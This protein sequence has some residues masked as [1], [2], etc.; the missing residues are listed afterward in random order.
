MKRSNVIKTMVLGGGLL[1]LITG[2]F[3]SFGAAGEVINI[4]TVAGKRADIGDGGLATAAQLNL[5]AAVAFGSAGA[6]YITEG[7]GHRVRK[8]DAAGI[9]TTFAGIGG[10]G[11]S[12][13]AGQAAAAQFNAPRGALVDSF[14]NLYIVET[15]GHRVRKI[16]VASGIVTTVVGTGVAG[17]A[18]DGGPATAAQLNAPGFAALDSS[19]NLYVSEVNANR[20]RKVVPGASGSIAGA[21]DEIISTVAGSGVAGSAG[22]GGLATAAQ[23]RNP[24]G[25]SVDASGNLYIADVNNQRVRKVDLEGIIT[26]FAGTGVAGFNGD[27]IQA[28]SAQLNG[29]RTISV[30]ASGSLYIADFNNN[31]VRKVNASGMITTIVGTGTRG[32]SGDDGLATAAQLNGPNGINIDPLGNLYISE[33]LG[34]HIRKVDTTGTITTFA[35]GGLPQL[36]DGG[37]ATAAQFDPTSGVAFDAS[38]NLYIADF[39]NNRVR[40]VD[41]LTGIISTFAGNGTTGSTGDGGQATAAQLNGP[42]AI[43]F[44]STGNLY[45]ADSTGR[46]VRKV[47]TAGV[48]TS[49]AGTGV[50]GSAGDGGPASSAQINNPQGLAIDS[51][52]NLYIS[53]FGGHRVRKVSLATGII[54]SVAGIGVTGFAGDSGAATAARLNSPQG[55]AV[56]P[57]G[58]LYIA[59]VGNN[60]I[61]K[62][63]TTGIITTFA[64]AG[65]T[66]FSGDGGLAVMAELN[67]PQSLAIDSSGTLYI[68]DVANNRIRKVDATGII[69]TVAGSGVGG[70]SGDG[71]PAALANL[72]GPRGIAIDLSHNIYV[73]D[74]GNTRIR[75]LNLA[76]SLRLELSSASVIL[77]W[78][79]TG[80]NFQLYEN[81]KLGLEDGWVASGEPAETNGAQMS[82]TLPVGVGPKFFRLNSD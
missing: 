4:M 21:S 53:E 31:R 64:G 47:D 40:K 11:S 75:R 15:G 48:V 57:S 70:F 49:F 80:L 18:G 66:S 58:V 60:R 28:T 3:P 16:S 32:F 26:T 30:D 77:S 71:G 73:T 36:G 56:D 61:R 14:G 22:D 44:D 62:V 1:Q 65:S 29:P 63:A 55:L 52:G 72:N 82:V 12:G 79:V 2:C 27:D 33:T 41:R 43:A 5:P 46:R 25:V 38:G 76:P 24:N 8:I 34:Q 6:R 37:P 67:S 20:I 13:D 69:T 10:S 35:G 39:N 54:T 59:D 50:S 23:L 78:P 45:I 81:T 42:F 17:S 68:A 7:A 9:I 74:S 51:F 19:G